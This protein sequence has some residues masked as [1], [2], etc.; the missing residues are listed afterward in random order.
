MRLAFR[1]Q[2]AKQLHRVNIHSRTSPDARVSTTTFLSTC[3]GLV[4]R[5]YAACLFGEVLPRPRR[6]A[7]QL[8]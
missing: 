1:H 3:Y 6:L 2:G 5:L 8:G 7:L 4:M